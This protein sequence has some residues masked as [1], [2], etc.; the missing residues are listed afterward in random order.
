MKNFGGVARRDIVIVLDNSLSTDR[1]VGD[2]N[3]YGQLKDN[4]IAILGDLKTGDQV[5]VLLTAAELGWLQIRADRGW[6]ECLC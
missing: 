1:K 5:R 6:Q 4:A 3:I 2:S